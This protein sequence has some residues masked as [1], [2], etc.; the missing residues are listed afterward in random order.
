MFGSS[1]HNLCQRNTNGVI[2]DRPVEEASNNRLYA[3]AFGERNYNGKQSAVHQKIG[4]SGKHEPQELALRYM[5]QPRRVV[6]QRRGYGCQIKTSS[7]EENLD[8][9]HFKFGLPE[10]LGRRAG[11]CQDYGLG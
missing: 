2:A 6:S 4:H 11:H 7:V 8:W 1:M 3:L 5:H 9:L 10:S